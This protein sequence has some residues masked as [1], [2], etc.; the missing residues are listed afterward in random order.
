MGPWCGGSTASGGRAWR[1]RMALKA[2]GRQAAKPPACH[3]SRLRSKSE[4]PR[5][6]ESTHLPRSSARTQYRRQSTMNCL[7]TGWLQLTVLP[8]PL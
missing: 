6:L 3:H 1:E 5:G 2:R 8:Q 7:T 4:H